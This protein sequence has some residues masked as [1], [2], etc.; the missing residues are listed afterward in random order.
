MLDAIDWASRAF[1]GKKN[2]FDKDPLWIRYDS[3][4][5]K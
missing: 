4:N 5:V 2:M 3:R 1:V